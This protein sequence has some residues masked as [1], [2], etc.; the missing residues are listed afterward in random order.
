MLNKLNSECPW[1]M[2]CCCFQKGFF[3]RNMPQSMPLHHHHAVMIN[4]ST[5]SST[6]RHFV[7]Y[8]ILVSRSGEQAV[9]FMQSQN[10]HDK[11]STQ[12]WKSLLTTIPFL[13]HHGWINM[14]ICSGFQSA[15]LTCY[16][17]SFVNSNHFHHTR[18]Y[19][20]HSTLVHGIHT[21]LQWTPL[22]GVLPFIYTYKFQFPHYIPVIW[23]LN[24]C[25]RHLK[26]IL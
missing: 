22:V 12:Q 1:A 13:I 16:P 6:G 21:I 26:L 20:L 15:M 11:K 18:S 23:F 7:A 2:N 8:D 9:Q 19:T 4:N 5:A 14:S 24:F 10:D 3:C 17:F 25:I